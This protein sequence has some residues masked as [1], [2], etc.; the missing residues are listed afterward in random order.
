MPPPRLSSPCTNRLTA[1]SLDLLSLCGLKYARAK[2]K[3]TCY[4]ENMPL[5]VLFVRD[6]DI[7]D[8]VRE[9][10]CDLGLVGLNVLEEKRLALGPRAIGAPLTRTGDPGHT[11]LTLGT[12]SRN[13][14]ALR[15][16]DQTP[17]V[18][19]T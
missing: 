4:G 1:A 5:D 3:L 16:I 15:D 10:V 9:D 2:D 17:L 19:R 7:P 11:L 6:D 18:G 12:M 13:P 8:L 14:L